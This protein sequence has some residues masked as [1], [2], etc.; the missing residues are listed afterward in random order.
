MKAIIE[1]L[2]G[3]TS[4]TSIL[5]ALDR[6]GIELDPGTILDAGGV[7]FTVREVHPLTYVLRTVDRHGKRWDQVHQRPTTFTITDVD[8]VWCEV[9]TPANQRWVTI[10]RMVSKRG[11]MKAPLSD[12]EVELLNLPPDAEDALTT[13][14]TWRFEDLTIKQLWKLT[15]RNGHA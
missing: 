9:R 13:P 11:G 5:D 8:E 3:G 2:D 12:A 7:T 4:V 14:G 15:Q 6:G 1:R 10:D